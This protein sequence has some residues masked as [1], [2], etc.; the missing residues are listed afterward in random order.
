MD[1]H[2]CYKKVLVFIICSYSGL[3]LAQEIGQ[4][5]SGKNG[6]ISAGKKEGAAAGIEMFN[7]GG[8]AADA[9]VSSLLV[10]S[11]KHIGAFCIG[12]EVPLIIYDAKKK[13]VKVK[14][15]YIL[16]NL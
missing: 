11:V 15:A 7:L 5:A 16:R 1:R 14:A 3:S 8:N 4:T 13:E 6:I 9:A 12:G 2:A 10:L